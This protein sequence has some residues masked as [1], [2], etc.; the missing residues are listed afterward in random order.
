MRRPAE[1][2]LE[3]PRNADYSEEWTLFD[4]S[5]QPIDLTS[6]VVEALA[7][8]VPGGTVVA[9][10]TIDKIEAVN[11]IIRMTWHGGDFA[12]FGSPF[13]TAK[14]AYDLRL[15]YPDAIHRI[16]ARGQLLITPE[17]TI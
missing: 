14:P 10:A 11:G 16:V 1:I 5:D 7:R 13:E 8:D 4:I 15:T 2:D 12:A 6:I 17:C 3:V 9:A